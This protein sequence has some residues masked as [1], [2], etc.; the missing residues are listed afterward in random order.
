MALFCN[1]VITFT[2]FPGLSEFRKFSFLDGPESES[3]YLLIMSSLYNCS[4]TT[5]RYAG[6][7]RFT[8]R[9][10]IAY[11]LSYSRVIFIATFLLTDLGVCPL[12]F[13]SDWF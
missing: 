10:S 6:G 8:P 3:W 11:C 5:G 13:G 9:P 4:D 7:T 12:V 2:V 1:F